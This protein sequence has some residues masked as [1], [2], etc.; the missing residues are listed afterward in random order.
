MFFSSVCGCVCVSVSVCVFVCLCLL[1]Q[2]SFV[3]LMCNACYLKAYSVCFEDACSTAWMLEIVN[4]YFL[5]SI[6]L[7]LCQESYVKS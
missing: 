1:D 5:V 4:I 3:F 6:I 2:F 7:T